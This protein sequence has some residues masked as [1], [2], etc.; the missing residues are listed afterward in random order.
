[1]RKRA[2]YSILLVN[3]KCALST[4]VVDLRV[5]LEPQV[6]VC[7]SGALDCLNIRYVLV[8]I[9]EGLERQSHCTL[10]TLYFLSECRGLHKSSGITVFS[11]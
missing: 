11:E 6:Y 4:V 10:N 5:F 1:M 8:V 3:W 2:S 7:E 9:S